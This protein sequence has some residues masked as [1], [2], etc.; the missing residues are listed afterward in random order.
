MYLQILGAALC[1][2]NSLLW[3]LWMPNGCTNN[4]RPAFQQECACPE[5]SKSCNTENY[6]L[7]ACGLVCMLAVLSG[8]KGRGTR[9]FLWFQ[10]TSF[11]DGSQLVHDMCHLLAQHI[12]IRAYEAFTISSM[13]IG[14][15]AV[16]LSS[17]EINLSSPVFIGVCQTILKSVW[18]PPFQK[19]TSQSIIAQS[20]F[21]PSQDDI[22]ASQTKLHGMTS[23]ER[24]H[25]W[26]PVEPQTLFPSWPLLL[27]YCDTQS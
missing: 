15:S 27:H 20:V 18:V 2:H 14:K 26:Q 3:D 12:R 23:T 21:E 24:G 25:L 8:P 19:V 1:G 16:S 9:E 22:F 6:C 17:I 13:V 7:W 5:V 10:G 4:S 11:I